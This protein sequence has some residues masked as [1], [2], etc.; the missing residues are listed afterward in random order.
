MIH[1]VVKMY[2]SQQNYVG[3]IINISLTRAFT[4]I[5][6]TKKWAGVIYF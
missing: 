5:A 2:K 4:R 3:F 6:A 1:M